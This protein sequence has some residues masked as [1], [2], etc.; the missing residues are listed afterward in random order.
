MTKEFL[1][2]G[3]AGEPES[4]GV[5]AGDKVE[6]RWCMVR[7]IHQRVWVIEWVS[8]SFNGQ[9]GACPERAT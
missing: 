6:T 2:S 8:G 7:T 1:V 9:G 4:G 3:L 5:L